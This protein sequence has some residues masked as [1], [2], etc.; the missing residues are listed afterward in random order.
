MSIYY[1]LILGEDK[2]YDLELKTVDD[3]EKKYPGI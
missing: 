2:I 3:I 1:E